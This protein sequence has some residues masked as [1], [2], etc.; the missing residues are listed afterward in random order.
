ME[1]QRFYK[2]VGVHE[3]HDVLQE[4]INEAIKQKYEWLR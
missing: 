3:A 4:R 2:K 1:L